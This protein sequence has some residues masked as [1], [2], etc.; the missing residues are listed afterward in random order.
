MAPDIRHPSPA[1]RRRG[2]VGTA[3][4]RLAGRW[5][6]W[7]GP[8][9]TGAAPAADPPTKWSETENVKWK[10]KL[11]GTGRSSPIVWGE[12]VFVQTAIPT[13]KKPESAAADS[14]QPP[15]SCWSRTSRGAAAPAARRPG[16]RGRARPRRPGRAGRAA[17]SGALGRRPPRPSVRHPL[18]RPRLPER[19]CGRRWPRKKCPTRAWAT[20]TVPTPPTSPVTDG[21]HIYAY[22]G[23][24]GLHCYDME[25][26]LK[27]SKDLGRMQTKNS[28]GEAAP[29]P[30]TATPSSSTGT[31]RGR[32][33]S[34]P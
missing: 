6:Q 28:F 16:R 22:F 11:P 20:A 26:N 4:R 25:G 29:P 14:P 33:S 31:T 3:G 15:T 21:K 34:S 23:S 30:C 8:L 5:P 12:Y 1:R 17:G 2:R 18:H 19:P 24:R 10:V 13:A 27:W 32:T 9:G 7:R